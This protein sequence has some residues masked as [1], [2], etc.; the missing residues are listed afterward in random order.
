MP[1]AVYPYAS[2]AEKR[3]NKSRNVNQ[4]L[5]AAINAALIGGMPTAINPHIKQ[6]AFTA[7]LLFLRAEINAE[8]I[9]A[10]HVLPHVGSGVFVM[11]MSN[12]QFKRES[13]Y[14][15]AVALARSMLA[16]GLITDKDFRK[17]D[18]MFNQ[19]YK[20]IIGGFSSKNP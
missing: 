10:M 4:N 2:N 1:T 12:E 11:T 9:V 13:K 7:V 19:K 8:N 16:K 3:W 6:P 17:V 15:A 14:G 20:P 18:T 5:S